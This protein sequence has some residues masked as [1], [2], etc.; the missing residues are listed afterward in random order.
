MEEEGSHVSKDPGQ[1][2]YL[3]STDTILVMKLYLQT[4]QPSLPPQL[5]FSIPS[6][7]FKTSHDFRENIL[8]H[9]NIK[10]YIISM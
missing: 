7:F 6:L 3:I 2:E 4:I 1:S 5:G 10:V 8:L 9:I